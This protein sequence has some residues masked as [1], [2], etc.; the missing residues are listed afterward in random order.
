[1]TTVRK[2]DSS[3]P[4][5][6]LYMAFELAESK[7]KL[8]FTTGLGKKP[9]EREI[10][11]RALACVEQE[12]QAAK[13]RFGLPAD[14]TVVSCYEAGRDGFWLHRYLLS[15][16][17]A[18]SIVESSSIEVNRRLRRAKTDRLDLRKLVKMLV[19]WHGGERDVWGVVNV[20]TPEA[21]DARQLHR[22][23]DT[24]RA[25]QTSHINRIKGLLAAS[26]LT[27]IVDR[28]LP[29]R[30]KKLR[31]WDGSPLATDLHRRLLREFERM[32]MLNRQIRELEKERAQR[33]RK[34]DAD[35]G[36]VQTRQLLK[37]KAIG[38]NSAWLYSREFFAWRKIRNRREVGSLAGLTGSPY[39]SGTVD[40]E[41]GISKA[42]NRR[43]LAM[44]IEIAWGWVRLQRQSALSR[45][46]ETR[47][48]HGGKRLRRIGIVAMARKLLVALWKYLE[49]GVPPAGAELVAWE[50]KIYDHTPSLQ[51]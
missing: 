14:A 5:A 15:L 43:V 19:R 21:E 20:P 1:M 27:V 17:V 39:R 29:T 41:L 30:L 51:A 25:E 3:T 49:S 32:Q 8:G 18:N 12:I 16:G 40:H 2:D 28:H 22:E 42:G 38:V 26:G 47:F 46:Y 4:A 11:A 35:V 34:D 33:V 48:A 7:W 37:L 10:E 31:L 45:W 23:L 9:R 50:K 36:V 44:S 13:E 24:L 6:V